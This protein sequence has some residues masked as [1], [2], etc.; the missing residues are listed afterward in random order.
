[1]DGSG[2]VDASHSNDRSTAVVLISL[3]GGDAD[4]GSASSASLELTL[5]DT[6]LFAYTPL[7][8]GELVGAAA[9]HQLIDEYTVGVLPA[10]YHEDARMQ[11]GRMKL[12]ATIAT[13]LYA[14]SGGMG[15]VTTVVQCSPATAGICARGRFYWMLRLLPLSQC[16]CGPIAC[17]SGG[18]C[19]ALR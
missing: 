11:A 13:A 12:D 5:G 19:S 14:D 8:T 6:L 2:D 3:Y 18:P 4:G 17:I 15:L 1:V 16:T 9:V 10:L 7:S